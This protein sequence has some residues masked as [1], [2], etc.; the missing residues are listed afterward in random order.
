VEQMGVSH[1][2]VVM[3]GVRGGRQKGSYYRQY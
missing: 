1:Y 3:H 2:L